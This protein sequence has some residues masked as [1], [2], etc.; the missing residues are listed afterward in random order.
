MA[1]MKKIENTNQQE[2]S[3]E[4]ARERFINGGGLVQADIIEEKVISQKAKEEWTRVLLRIRSNILEEIDRLV[5]DRM[6]MTR[7]GWMLE[8]IQEKL[9]KEREL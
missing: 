4:G 1:F 2:A 7:T 3:K 6:G 8:A 5:L 9:R